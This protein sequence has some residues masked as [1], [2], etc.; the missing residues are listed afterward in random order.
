MSFSFL[1]YD[2]VHKLVSAVQKGKLDGCLVDAY[3]ADFNT[4]FHVLENKATFQ[5]REKKYGVV[6]NES[7]IDPATYNLFDMYMNANAQLVQNAIESNTDDFPVRIMININ[8][9]HVEL[10]RYLTV[11]KIS[12][13]NQ[14]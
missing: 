6:F 3:V 2:N 9:F 7:A 4:N 11:I 1:E 13:K 12:L 14:P 8:H 10:A 5:E